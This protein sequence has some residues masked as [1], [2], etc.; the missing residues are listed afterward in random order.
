M[1]SDAALAV[2]RIAKDSFNSGTSTKNKTKVTYEL[3]FRDPRTDD[4]LSTLHF[5]LSNP[6]S[7]DKADKIVEQMYPLISSELGNRTAASIGSQLLAQQGIVKKIREDVDSSFEASIDLG[8]SNSK[9]VSGGVGVAG[10]VRTAAGRFSTQKNIK[11]SLELLMKENLLRT[12]TGPSAGKG[13]NT[14]L[15]NRTGRFVNSTEV[16][17]ILVPEEPNNNISI[18]YKYMVYPYQVFDPNHTQSPDMGLAS[19]MRNPQKLI[20]DA[21]KGAAR[22]LLNKKYRATIR[23]VM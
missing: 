19:R 7:E 20:G 13:H 10:A 22:T 15:R 2:L 12:M 8:L 4:V 16:E 5:T 1:M 14:P 21:L 23:Q 11:A 9:D 17:A 6:I 3:D 18:Y